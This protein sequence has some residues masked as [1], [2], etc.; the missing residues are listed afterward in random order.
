MVRR[1]A[2]AEAFLKKRVAEV[3]VVSGPI[4]AKGYL[5]INFIGTR[6]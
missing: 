4:I 6:R 3:F 1:L 2:I 5:K